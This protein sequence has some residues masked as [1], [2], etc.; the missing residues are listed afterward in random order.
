MLRTF[1]HNL[2]FW[3][4]FGETGEVSL[5]LSA[6]GTGM[7]PEIYLAASSWEALLSFPKREGT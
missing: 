6:Q 5:S 1:L 4:A 2:F 7:G 3:N